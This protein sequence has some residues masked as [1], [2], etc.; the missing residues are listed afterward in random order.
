MKTNGLHWWRPLKMLCANYA[1]GH[2]SKK[3]CFPVVF[4]FT[5]IEYIIISTFL[6]FVN[7]N[8]WAALMAPSASALQGDEWES[9]GCYNS[10]TWFPYFSVRQEHTCT[11]IALSACANY[12]QTMRKLCA[13]WELR[14]RERQRGKEMDVH[15][16][17]THH[18]Q[19]TSQHAQTMRKPCATYAQKEEKRRTKR[20]MIPRMKN[21]AQHHYR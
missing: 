8:Q 3:W 11:R 2:F 1:H 7:E 14:E 20:E 19:S 5:D 6:H 17:H 4:Q 15:H 9:L 21:S 10:W 18:H 13:D 16:E 12:A